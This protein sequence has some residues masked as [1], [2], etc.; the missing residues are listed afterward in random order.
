MVN[1]WVVRGLRLGRTTHPFSYTV[2][3]YSRNRSLYK[4]RIATGLRWDLDR[5]RL[6][7]ARCL[8]RACVRRALGDHDQHTGFQVYLLVAQPRRA[9]AFYDVLDFV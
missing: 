3:P 5:N 2:T 8:H 1:P 4:C 6:E 9:R 7:P